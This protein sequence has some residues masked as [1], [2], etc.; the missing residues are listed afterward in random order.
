MVGVA[1]W[2]ARRLC[3]VGP[4]R[5]D[6]KDG[7]RQCPDRGGSR[8]AQARHRA[9]GRAFA[10]PP[11]RPKADGS[12][13]WREEQHPPLRLS[14]RAARLWGA[15]VH[16]LRRPARGR[17]RRGGAS[18]CRPARCRRGGAGGRRAGRRAW[19]GESCDQG[20]NERAE[21]GF[22]ATACIVHELEEAEVERQL[23][24][25]DP[26]GRAEPGAQQGPEPLDRVDGHLAE[27]VAILV[28]GVFAAPVADRFVL[29]PPGRQAGVDAILV[30]MD[31]R[32]FGNRGR[33]DRLDRRLLH[34]GQ[35]VQ[36]YLTSALDQA[37]NGWLVLLPR[38]PARRA[39]QPASTSEPP[40]LATAAGWPL[41]PATP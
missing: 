34:V 35:H 28:A 6:P 5:G 33:D 36:D 19:S 41:W 2:R 21:E 24:L 15:E 1:A 22:A 30:G 37:E 14:P 4:R 38:A 27:P 23:L 40:L 31:E 18:R 7:E 10:L 29:I 9:S 8:R 32:A 3:R 12:V 26:P 16:R 13:H 11:L 17:R 39:G 25:R 20:G